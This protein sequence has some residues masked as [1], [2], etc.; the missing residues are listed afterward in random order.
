M[1]KFILK[2]RSEAISTPPPADQSSVF[3]FQFPD[4]AGF[5][6]RCNRLVRIRDNEKE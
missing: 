5:S 1:V 3:N 6:L 4:I 2:K